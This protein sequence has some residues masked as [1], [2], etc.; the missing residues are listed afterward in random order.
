M[1]SKNIIINMFMNTS[2]YCLSSLAQKRHRSVVAWQGFVIL[3][4]IGETL[5][6]FQESG[7]Y[8]WSRER[9][10]TIENG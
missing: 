10:K 5:A 6:S 1:V 7:K 4:E 3:F 9:L 2:F 8:P